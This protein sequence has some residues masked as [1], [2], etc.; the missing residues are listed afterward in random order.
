MSDINVHLIDFPEGSKT[1]ESVTLNEDGTYS[2]FINARDAS[3]IQQK[4]YQHALKH[5][6][7]ADFE[8]EKSVQ[9]L[10]ARAHGRSVKLPQKS[11]KRSR[12]EAYHKKQL[13]KEKGLRKLGL[14][15]EQYF[16]DDEYGC[17]TVRYRIRKI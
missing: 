7:N 12:W 16:D 10:E 8:P 13:R 15:R 4:A 11:K 17:P 9:V 1:H 14:V 6:K 5:I 2:V 3:N